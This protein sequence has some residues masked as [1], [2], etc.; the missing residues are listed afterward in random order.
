MRKIAIGLGGF[1]MGLHCVLAV[2]SQLTLEA[3]VRADV[4]AREATLDGMQMQ[5]DL[6]L[7]SASP[8]ALMQ[9]SMANQASVDAVFTTYGTT[10]ARHSAEWTQ[11]REAVDEW[12]TVHFDWQQTYQNLDAK[13][14]SLAQQLDSLRTGP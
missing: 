7:Q 1:I 2:A 6:R 11:Q 12:L 9:A 5:I 3:L 10:G 8:D 4:Q 14:Q 13:F